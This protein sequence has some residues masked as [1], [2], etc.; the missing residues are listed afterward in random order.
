MDNRIIINS[1][2]TLLTI[3]TFTT[4]ISLG[5]HF[6]VLPIFFPEQP[7]KVFRDSNE[8]SLEELQTPYPR[9]SRLPVY[10]AE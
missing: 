2:K 10:T 1:M 9:D 3:L 8:M 5:V 6:Y 4:V 7:A